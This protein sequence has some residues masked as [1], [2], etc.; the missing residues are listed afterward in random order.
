MRTVNN[1]ERTVRILKSSTK[2]C[3]YKDYVRVDCHNHWFSHPFSIHVYWD[4]II[5][6]RRG[7]DYNGKVRNVKIHCG[8]YRVEI[9]ETLVHGIYQFDEEETN[10]DQIVV[11]FNPIKE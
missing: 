9:P 3:E 4:K 1:E 6:K 5:F 11:Y 10:E 8:C 7:I 2:G